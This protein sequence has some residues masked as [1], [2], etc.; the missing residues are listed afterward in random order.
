MIH[1][2]HTNHRHQYLHQHQF[3]FLIT[4]TLV[5]SGRLL[6]MLTSPD[7]HHEPYGHD[8]AI[9][10]NPLSQTPQKVPLSFPPVWAE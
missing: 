10:R 6:C 9:Y 7:S 5:A 3:C 4:E 8:L 1:E 2:I